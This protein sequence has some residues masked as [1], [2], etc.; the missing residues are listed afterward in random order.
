M[1][2][3]FYLVPVLALLALPALAQAQFEAGNWELKLA[4]QGT[5]D[6][7]FTGGTVALSGSLGY[8][9]TKEFEVGVRQG[10][11]WADALGD[12]GGSSWAGDTRVFAD[13]HFDAD[14]WQ[15]YV[16]AFLGYIYGDAA[17]D[18]WVAGPEVGVK[19][20]V[21]STT[22][23]DLNAAYAFD[24]E[25]GFSDGAFFYQLGLGFRW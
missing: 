14:R 5:N 8:F 3:K 25:E 11:T 15:P 20:F 2:R 9:T 1:L 19:Y 18:T 7:D 13:F 21:N 4:G 24:L 23:I 16:G 12:G 22:F 10:L 6:V 17:N